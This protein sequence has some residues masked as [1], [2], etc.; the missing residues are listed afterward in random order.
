MGAGLEPR[1]RIIMESIL[2]TNWSNEPF[3]HTWDKE[4]FTFQPGQSIYLQ[5]YLAK[6]F[7]KHLANRELMKIQDKAIY[8]GN[9]N[10]LVFMEFRD[11]ALSQPLEASTS[12]QAEIVTIN[13][14]EGVSSEVKR[15]CDSCDSKGVRHKKDCP[16][17]STLKKSE[18]EEEFA[19]LKE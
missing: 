16:K 8:A 13:R 9:E 1:Q 18:D 6:H 5:D 14:N 3:T 11:K 19:D 2:F 10:S 4:S 12:L 17:N 7:A 15:F